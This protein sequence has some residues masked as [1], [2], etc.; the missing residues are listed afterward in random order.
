MDDLIYRG[1]LLKSLYEDCKCMNSHFLAAVRLAPAVTRWIPVEDAFPEDGQRVLIYS[2]SKR[3]FDVVFRANA[4]MPYF[5]TKIFG[6]VYAWYC[7]DV[8]KWMPLPEPPEK[9]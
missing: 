8:I 1:K 7:E 6:K 9:E 3:L 5:D 2:K 4:Q